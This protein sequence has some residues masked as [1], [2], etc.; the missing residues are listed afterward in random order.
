MAA[1]SRKLTTSLNE[2]EG[3]YDGYEIVVECADEITSVV[4]FKGSKNPFP[5]ATLENLRDHPVT[6]VVMGE[7]FD[8]CKA[9]AE[10]QAGEVINNGD[11]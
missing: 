2:I 4:Y 11:R 1:T 6:A 5:M 9:C 3:G 10:F 7:H 8:R